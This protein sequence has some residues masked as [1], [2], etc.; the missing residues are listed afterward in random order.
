[1]ANIIFIDNFDS[2]SYNLVDEFRVLGNHVEVYRNNL[3][4][5]VLLDKINSVDNPIVVI[6]P[7]PGNPASAGCIVDLISILK[8]KVP[9]IGICLGHQA[10]VEAYGGIVSHANEIIH[11]KTAKVKFV[12]HDIFKDLESPLSVARYHSL[13]A[14]KVPTGL[15]TVA[16]VN[17]LVMA[18]VDDKNKI[19]GLQFHPESIMTIHGSKL[20]D[21]I[22]KWVQQ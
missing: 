11:G 16:E 7:G 6:S 4:L 15:E 19:C 2:F 10:I 12:K 1:M 13:V 20:L 5:D 3:Y 22:V 18:V 9:I 17:D 14:I 8:G 21:N